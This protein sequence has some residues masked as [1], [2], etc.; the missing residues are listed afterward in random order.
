M[1]GNLGLPSQQLSRLWPTVRT[2]LCKDIYRIHSPWIS[3]T[4]PHLN[5]ERPTQ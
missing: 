5:N 1:K 4:N 2:R 3:L